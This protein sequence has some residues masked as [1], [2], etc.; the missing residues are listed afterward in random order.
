MSRIV[1]VHGIAQQFKGPDSLL[2]EWL[3]SLRDGVTLAKGTPPTADEVAAAFY[4]DLFR[5]AGRGIG[6]PDLDASDIVDPFDVEL[7]V[8]WWQAAALEDPAVPGLD[9][10]TRVRTPRI[11]QRA[12]NALGHSASFAHVADRAMVSDL[13]QVRRYLAEP[14]LR[15]SVLRRVEACVTEQTRILIG[16]SLGSVVAYEALCA[17]PQWP[18]E[19]FISLGSPLGLRG[20]IFERLRPAPVSGRGA[21]P[22]GIRSWTNIADRGDAVAGEKHLAGLF[23]PGVVDVPVHNGSH[24]HDI[25]PYLS[26]RETG[27]AVVAAAGG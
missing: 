4:G 6:E 13:R 11:A 21:W 1:L 25:R 20:L 27:E 18:V 24:A 17:N 15:S 16:H 2:A 26:A 10:D 7:L 5:P 19:A 14:E 8:S 9:A 22:G 23:G 3:P 12:L